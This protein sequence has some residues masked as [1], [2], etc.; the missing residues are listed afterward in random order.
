MIDMKV[1]Y[2]ER[3]TRNFATPQLVY[4]IH[5]RCI[6]FVFKSV[7]RFEWL[8][9][10]PTSLQLNFDAKYLTSLFDQLTFDAFI[11]LLK[12]NYSLIEISSVFVLLMKGNRGELFQVF[13]KNSIWAPPDSWFLY[14]PEDVNS[15]RTIECLSSRLKRFDF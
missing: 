7:K 8:G 9:T 15:E 3:E 12:A 10:F 11:F 6:L 2:P 1:G 14:K 5:I 13:L 4:E